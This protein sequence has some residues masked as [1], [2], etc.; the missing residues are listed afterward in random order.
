MERH[1]RHLHHKGRGEGQEEPELYRIAESAT[2]QCCQVKCVAATRGLLVKIS[3]GDDARQ[4]QQTAKRGI[5]HKLEGRVDTPLAS[6]TANQ[7]I[8]RNQHHF[9]ENIEEEEIGGE[10]DADD[11]TFEQQHKGHIVLDLLLD[12]K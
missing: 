4:H 7:E 12:A 11:A 10:E 2:K 8:G 1:K 5:E 6:P 3:Q 9:P